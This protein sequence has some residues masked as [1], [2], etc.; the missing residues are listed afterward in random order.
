MSESPIPFEEIDRQAAETEAVE[1]LLTFSSGSSSISIAVCNSPALRDSIV[2]KLRERFEIEVVSLPDGTADPF[3]YVCE[4]QKST[5]PPALFITNLE[6]SV[7][8]N[9]ERQPAL[10]SINAARELW[11]ER[12]GCPIVFWR[13][14]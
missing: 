9:E 13:P 8:S 11:R 6:A 12:F 14:E 3:D 5:S 7:P 1:R 10:H 4:T 2:A